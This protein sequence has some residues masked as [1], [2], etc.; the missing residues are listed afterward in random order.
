MSKM[1][2]IPGSDSK[3][4]RR[5]WLGGKGVVSSLEWRAREWLDSEFM[6]ETCR[7]DSGTS[8]EAFGGEW[9]STLCLRQMGN[10]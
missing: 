7:E 4:E 5:D 2:K 6:W 3:E 1:H 8:V 9:T 10:T